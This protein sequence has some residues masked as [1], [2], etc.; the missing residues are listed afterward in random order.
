MNKLNRILE[1]LKDMDVPEL[2]RGDFQ[3]LLRNLYIRNSK[4]PHYNEVMTLIK[5]QIRTSK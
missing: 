1:L 3:W 4:H 5:E 2:R